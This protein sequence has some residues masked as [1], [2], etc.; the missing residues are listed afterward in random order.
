VLIDRLAR[1][2]TARGRVNEC[3]LLAGADVREAP[4]NFCF[5]GVGSTDIPILERHFR[6]LTLRVG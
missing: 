4:I 5:W 6:F 1:R 3:L 2:Q